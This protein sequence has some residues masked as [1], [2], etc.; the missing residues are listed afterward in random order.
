MNL[1]R[2]HFFNFQKGFFIRLFGPFEFYWWV[3]NHVSDGD[4]RVHWE[5]CGNDE[6][7]AAIW[8]S[9][10]PHHSLSLS[11]H[12]DMNINYYCYFLLYLLMAV[13]FIMEVSKKKYFITITISNMIDSQPTNKKHTKYIIHKEIT[14]VIQLLHN[15]L[16]NLKFCSNGYL[17]ILHIIVVIWIT[18]TFSSFSRFLGR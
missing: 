5:D 9:G 16:K 15:K 17:F 8:V 2:S 18:V 4:A 13:Y 3:M 14:N 10:W 6:E 1:S 11:L 7:W 12:T